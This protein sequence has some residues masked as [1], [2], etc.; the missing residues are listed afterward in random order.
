MNMTP[1]QFIAA[2]PRTKGYDINVGY[3]SNKVF[4][5]N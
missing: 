1:Y 4:L 2:K 3:R 5:R